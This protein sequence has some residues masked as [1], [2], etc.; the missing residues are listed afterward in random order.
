MQVWLTGVIEQIPPF[1]TFVSKKAR[2]ETFQENFHINAG[3]PSAMLVSPST[4]QTVF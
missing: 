3:E 1:C 4:F 2:N